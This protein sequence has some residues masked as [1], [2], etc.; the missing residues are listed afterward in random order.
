MSMSKGTHE[1]M[2]FGRTPQSQAAY[3]T[4]DAIATFTILIPQLSKDLNVK[5]LLS[6]TPIDTKSILVAYEKDFYPWYSD[7]FKEI[8]ADLNRE[9]RDNK[10]EKEPTEK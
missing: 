10:E 2:L 7:W 3:L 9:D 4:I 5:T 6:L 8:N 1:Q